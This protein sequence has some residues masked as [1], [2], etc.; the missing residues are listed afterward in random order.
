MVG[1]NAVL[2]RPHGNQVT[3]STAQHIPGGGAD[4]E[5]FA[6]VFVHGNHRGFTDDNTLAVYIYQDIGGTQI[7]TEIS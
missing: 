7:D 1:D 5:D 3:G 2:Q 6:G 4:L